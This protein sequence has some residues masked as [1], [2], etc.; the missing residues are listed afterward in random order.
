MNRRNLL[1]AAAASVM[2]PSAVGASNVRA[3]NIHPDAE[4]IAVCAEFDACERQTSIIHGSGPDCVIDD[5][6]ARLVSAPF[7]DRMRVL[8]DRMDGLRATTSAGIQARAHCLA[9]HGGHGDYDF[10]SRD[11]MVGRLQVYLMRDSTALG[12]STAIVPVPPSPDGEL[13]AACAAFDALER[14]YVAAVGDYEPGSDEQV[15]AEAKQERVSDAQGPLIKRMCSLHA[16]T[17]EGHAARA[18]SLALWDAELMKPAPG[19]TGKSL[20]AA[21]VRDLLAGS[22]VA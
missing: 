16:T 11:T 1:P 17:R 13:L 4:L 22:A 12:G 8:L 2:L 18:R 3:S 10:G 14:A 7:F 15:V 6:E 5:D 19:D 21:I 9:Q 20:T